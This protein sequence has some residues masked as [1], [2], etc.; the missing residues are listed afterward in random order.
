MVEDYRDFLCNLFDVWYNDGQPVPSIRLF[1][2]IL[3]IGMGIE[4]EICAFKNR[5]GS[6]VVVEYD[7]DAYPFFFVEEQYMLED[8]DVLKDHYHNWHS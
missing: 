6:D 8:F 2:N 4:P 5:C 1:E 3:V 7:S